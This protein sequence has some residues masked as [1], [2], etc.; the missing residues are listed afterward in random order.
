MLTTGQA[1]VQ[2]NRAKA[3][4]WLP[5]FTG[6]G[7]PYGYSPQLLLAIASRETNIMNI[8]GDV[9]HDGPHG[10][11][12]MQIDK[13]S[14][15]DFCLSGQWKNVEASIRMGALVLHSKQIEIQHGQGA[16]IAKTRSYPAF[17][18]APIPDADLN[19]CSI[20]AYNAGIGAYYG[21][22]AH[23][24]PDR[25]TTGHDYS[26]DVIARMLIFA[27]LLTGG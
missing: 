27:G 3:N 19:R 12:L 10:F 15:P 24:D 21:F 13:G 22:T 8:V 5:M 26:A 23:Q 14:Y 6:A 25:F 2:F 11:G 9:Q 20:A 7:A 18:G 16:K 17:V 1:Q 4:G